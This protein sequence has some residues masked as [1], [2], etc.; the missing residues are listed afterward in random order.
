MAEIDSPLIVESATPV[1]ESCSDCSIANHQYA[2]AVKLEQ[3]AEFVFSIAAGDAKPR[4]INELIEPN[5]DLARTLAQAIHEFFPG[6]G[7]L[8]KT[9]RDNLRSLADVSD[10]T[11][12]AFIEHMHRTMEKYEKLVNDC[13]NQGLRRVMLDRGENQNPIEL[14]LCAGEIQAI[15]LNKSVKDVP[16]TASA[17]KLKLDNNPAT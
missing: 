5:E 13:A 17:K 15:Q 1:P 11:A 9:S 4:E 10:G 12:L 3:L 2:N 8:D 6:V 16:V 14:T 7:A